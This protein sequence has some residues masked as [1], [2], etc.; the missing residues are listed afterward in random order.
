MRLLNP[1]ESNMK[2]PQDQVQPLLYS[3]D[4]LLHILVISTVSTDRGVLRTM[5]LKHRTSRTIFT[6]EYMYD[7][8]NH[9]WGHRVFI[10]FTNPPD[11]HYYCYSS[12]YQRSEVHHKVIIDVVSLTIAVVL[13]DVSSQWLRQYGSVG[14][15]SLHSSHL[16]Q[17]QAVTQLNIE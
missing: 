17:H 14:F 13:P 3:Y 16:P 8:N 15:R 2:L 12:Q 7:T 10:P 5:T 6:S 1:G 11:A 4:S 9:F